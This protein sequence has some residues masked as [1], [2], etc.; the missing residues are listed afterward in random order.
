MASTSSCRA[1]EAIASGSSASSARTRSRA[2]RTPGSRDHAGE[3]L[4]LAGL[5][6]VHA[7]GVVPVPVALEGPADGA[8]VVVGEV[9]VQVLL[10]GDLDPL[11]EKRSC[12]ERSAAARCPRSRRRSRR[13]PPAAA[14]LPARAD[15]TSASNSACAPATVAAGRSAGRRRCPRGP[16]RSRRGGAS[17]SSARRLHR[18]P[19][20]RG[21]AGTS[22]RVTRR[23]AC[24]VARVAGFGAPSNCFPQRATLSSIPPPWPGPKKKTAHSPAAASRGPGPRTW[25]P[26]SCSPG[27]PSSAPARSRRCPGR[28]GW[29]GGAAERAPGTS[30]ARGGE[31]QDHAGGA[32]S[33]GR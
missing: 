19:P 11:R 9:G 21:S 16:R 12:S 31:S 30:R 6:P 28:G 29:G 24:R 13:P 5:D 17:P 23:P 4:D 32:S 14:W 25:P 22:A 10:L 18:R 27:R 15:A 1:P 7:G 2:P 26:A 8:A 20:A 3:D 33:V